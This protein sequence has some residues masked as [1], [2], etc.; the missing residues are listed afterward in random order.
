MSLSAVFFLRFENANSL[1]NKLIRETITSTER[2]TMSLPLVIS[3]MLYRKIG[4]AKRKFVIPFVQ[5]KHEV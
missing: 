1:K 3:T 4:P 2:Q 5:I